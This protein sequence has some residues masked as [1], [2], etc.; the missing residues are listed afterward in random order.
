[1]K[2]I[3]LRILISILILVLSKK[4]WA[5]DYKENLVTDIPATTKIF[6]ESIG[7][8]ARTTTK[9]VFMIKCEGTNSKGTGFLIKPGY[10]IT[11][12]HVI[13]GS[14]LSEIKI[15]SFHSDTIRVANM[16]IDKDRD[17]AALLPTKKLENGLEIGDES[18][19]QI[20]EPLETWGFPLGYNGP[21][22][23][24]SGGFL[25]GIR[26]AKIMINKFLSDSIKYLVV[27]GA[28]NNGNSGGP[29]FSLRGN[30]VIGI[31]RSKHAP[32]SDYDLLA[33]EALKENSTGV[34]YTYT[35]KAG[36][37]KNIVESQ[38]VANMLENF[39][40]LTQVVIGEAI[41]AKD[42]KYFL[43]KNNIKY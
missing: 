7:E 42:L 41:S 25:S 36:N 21:N 2:N 20:G 23:L 40:S 37:K 43:S 6:T 34:V 10:V 24:F 35:D 28:F 22:P 29:L 31:V 38:I 33:I 9:S 32:I 39:R 5:Q 27:N 4:L 18:K 1:M 3:W 8:V 12:E 17:I 16:I 15:I 19:L 11:N 26:I 14:I 30:K 13:R